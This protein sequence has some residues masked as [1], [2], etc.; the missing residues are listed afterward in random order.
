MWLRPMDLFPNHFHVLF[1]ILFVNDDS[2]PVSS[3]IFPD[4]FLVIVKSR[5]ESFLA[6]EQNIHMISKVPSK[7]SILIL[8]GE[9]DTQTPVQQ[10][11]LLQQRLT[12]V[13]HPDHTLI[14]YPDLGHEFH[15]S[16]QWFS[17]HGPIPEYVLQDLFSWLSKPIHNWGV[18]YSL[19]KVGFCE[20]T[21]IIKLMTRGHSHAAST[22]REE[23]PK[24]GIGIIE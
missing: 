3:S 5:G 11:L 1:H 10:A 17:E 13:K 12:E 14:T 19:R 9:N 4:S 15:P 22:Q 23:E 20:L 2:T 24:I 18:F 21:S 6:F 16:S 7:T 8:N